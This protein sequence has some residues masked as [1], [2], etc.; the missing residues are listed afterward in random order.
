MNQFPVMPSA[1]A[2][3]YG[4]LLQEV[5]AGTARISVSE[6]LPCRQVKVKRNDLAT[7]VLFSG[8][9]YCATEGWLRLEASI[10]GRLIKSKYVLAKR[11]AQPARL[12]GLEAGILDSVT[13]KESD[14]GVSSIV[15]RL[16]RRDH[17]D[18]WGYVIRDLRRYLLG[19][20]YFTES[21]RGGV[22]K[23]LGKELVPDCAKIG[24][25]RTE[26]GQVGNL[27]A[28]F[29]S[30]QGELYAQLWKDVSAGITSRQETPQEDLP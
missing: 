17:V 21:E 11:T 12:E 4:D 3:L 13:G 24:A 9:V 5:F 14:D 18:P 23:L 10:R 29:R 8:F 26:A 22:R 16:L 28:G 27:L 7:V 20:G 1:L 19:P 30:A 2:Y 25:L 15:A 6:T